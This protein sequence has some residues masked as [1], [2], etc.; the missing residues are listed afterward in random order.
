MKPIKLINKQIIKDA[1]CFGLQTR[2]DRHAKIRR[3]VSRHDRPR[4]QKTV[5]VKE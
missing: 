3:R 4:I 2:Y 5:S 1:V